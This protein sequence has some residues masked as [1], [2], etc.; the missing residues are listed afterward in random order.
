LRIEQLR[1]TNFRQYRDAVIDL[2]RD[3]DSAIVFVGKT[4]AGKTNLLN[5]ITWCLYGYQQFGARTPNGRSMPMVNVGP[6][7]ERLAVGP[8]VCSVEIRLSFDDGRSAVLRRRQTFEVLEAGTPPTPTGQPEFSIQTMNSQRGFDTVADT[9]AW[10]RTFMP[11]RVRP[12][13]ILNTER[14]EQFFHQDTEP[15]RVRDAI[16]QIAQIDL[17]VRMRKRLEVVKGDL[18]SAARGK[19]GSGLLAILERERQELDS[20]RQRAEDDI[21]TKAR[22]LE[23]LDETIASID[24]RMGDFE[25]AAHVVAERNEKEGRLQA[26]ATEYD[27]VEAEMLKSLA[28]DAPSVFAYSAIQRLRAHIEEAWKAGRIPAPVHPD[29]LQRLLDEEACVCGRP[30]CQGSAEAAAVESKRLGQ[31][32]ATVLGQFLQTQS[33]PAAVH[34]SRAEGMK[35]S[36]ASTQLR[37]ARLAEEARQLRARIEQLTQQMA[38]LGVESASFGILKDQW[39]Q[40]QRAREQARMDIALAK[41]DL[42]SM[43]AKI[44]D[45]EKKLNIEMRKDRNQ[46]ELAELVRFTERCLEAVGKAYQE[47]VTETRQRVSAALNASFLGDDERGLDGMIWKKETYVSATIDDEYNVCVE[48]AAGY[49][50]EADLSGGEDVCL[51]LAFSQALGEISGFELPLIFDSPLVKLDDEVKVKVARSMGLN[52]RGRQLILLMKPDEY[53]PDV[54]AALSEGVSVS[55]A[56]LKFDEA[57]Q[58]TSIVS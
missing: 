5:A 37:L 51:A 6:L 15:T 46:Q 24:Q 45:V 13:Y 8:S 41:R 47:L 39:D 31:L 28:K 10:I 12:Y 36:A 16:L 50:A 44:D 48:H 3:S 26:V 9:D 14:I 1:L 38:E 27:Q 49:S 34:V 52:L 40:A 53:N 43:T 17:L 2:G 20:G 32:R 25:E 57:G 18:Y 7:G 19:D 29:Y 58:S 22:D 33:G 4:G 30:L 42:E 11:E 23:H 56:T 21:E 55:A 54:Q 35:Q